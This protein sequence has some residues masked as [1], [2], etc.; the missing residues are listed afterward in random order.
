[1]IFIA[2]NRIIDYHQTPAA[3]CKG[4]EADSFDK[5]V[6]ILQGIIDKEFPGVKVTINQDTADRRTARYLI[7]HGFEERDILGE[8][9]DKPMEMIGVQVP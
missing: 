5:A 4:I 6:E 8:M 7:R 3:Q 9:H 2:I 1:M